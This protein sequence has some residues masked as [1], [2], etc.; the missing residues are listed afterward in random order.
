[1]PG[2]TSPNLYGCGY[3]VYGKNDGPT[4]VE[5]TCGVAYGCGLERS[6]L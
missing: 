1:M 6:L 5:V 2:I 3:G 4:G